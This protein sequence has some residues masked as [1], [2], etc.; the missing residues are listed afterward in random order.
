M[1]GSLLSYGKTAHGKIMFGKLAYGKTG[2][3]KM[4]SYHLK[5]CYYFADLKCQQNRGAPT[6]Q[7]PSKKQ[8]NVSTSSS[9]SKKVE[10]QQGEDKQ[11]QHHPMLSTFGSGG[12]AKN[13]SPKQKQFQQE[14]VTPGPGQGLLSTKSTLVQLRRS[15]NTK[16]KQ[17]PTPPRR[18][19]LVVENYGPLIENG[20]LGSKFNK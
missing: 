9:Q 8:R 7:L 5:I 16:G 17:A 4:T 1:L 13:P 19:R 18:T 12:S 15:T 11:L 10:A 2:D 6:P 20:E 14:V 3:G